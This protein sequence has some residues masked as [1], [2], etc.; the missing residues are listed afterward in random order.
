MAKIFKTG[1]PEFW[2]WKIPWNSDSQNIQN[3]IHDNTI[4]CQICEIK[5]AKYI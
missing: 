2:K 1:I 4:W 3:N 5:T